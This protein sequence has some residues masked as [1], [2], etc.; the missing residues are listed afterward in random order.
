MPNKILFSYFKIFSA[1]ILFCCLATFPAFAQE[2]SAVNF[3]QPNRSYRALTEQENLTTPKTEEKK[4]NFWEQQKTAILQKESN[5][6]KEIKRGGD[7]E[8]GKEGMSTLS[9]NLFL[10]VVDRF[11]EKE[12]I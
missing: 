1:S 11:K 2:E 12:D 10:Y 9:F 3:D 6:E 7:K 5:R 4:E 8:T